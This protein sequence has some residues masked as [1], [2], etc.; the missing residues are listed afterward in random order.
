MTSRQLLRVVSWL[1]AL[2]AGSAVAHASPT[3]PPLLKN[4]LELAEI[5]YG[6]LGCQLC[7]SDDTGGPMTVTT[8][9]G[10]AMLKAGT[11]G[12]N[13]PSMLAALAALEATSNDSDLDG[14]PD[15]AELKA[16]EDPNVPAEGSGAPEVEQ[17]PLPQTGCSTSRQVDAGWPGLLLV[18]ANMLMLAT[19]RSKAGL[20]FRRLS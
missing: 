7:H 15:I 18:V 3:F 9:F 5:P 19:R 10:R 20:L 11:Q 4:K 12:A 6:P 2:V 1:T 14:I 8:P 17:V 16:G 13:P